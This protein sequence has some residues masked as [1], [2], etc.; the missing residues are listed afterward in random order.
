MARQG[1]PLWHTTALGMAMSAFIASICFLR[2]ERPGRYYL[3]WVVLRGVCGSTYWGLALFA[4]TLGASPGDVGSLMSVNVAMAALLG[5]C[6]LKEPLG[7]THLLSTLLT[8]TGAV[9]ISQ[10]SFIFQETGGAASSSWAGNL[11][12]ILAGVIQSFAF[13]CS[14]QVAEFSPL[15]AT[16]SCLIIASAICVLLP[17]VK[18]A[19][20]VPIGVM[21]SSPGVAVAWVAASTVIGLSGYGGAVFGSMLCPAAASTTAYTSGCMVFG[22]AAEFLFF[23]TSPELVRL[24][25]AALMVVAIGIMA[26]GNKR[27]RES[28]ETQLPTQLPDWQG[29]DSLGSDSL[30]LG[31]QMGSRRA[32]LTEFIFS[33]LSDF[34]PVSEGGRQRMSERRLSMRESARRDSARSYL[35]DLRFRRASSQSGGTSGGRASLSLDAIPGPDGTEDHKKASV[36]DI[37]EL[38]EDPVVASPEPL[39]SA[40]DGPKVHGARDREEPSAEAVPELPEKCTQEPVPAG[41]P[42]VSA[43]DGHHV[44][45]VSGMHPPEEDDDDLTFTI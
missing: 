19:D 44:C 9:L 45:G 33:E 37:P 17:A 2:P 6:F 21:W 18:L 4:V 31:S 5:R 22:Y 16:L 27:P 8:I 30:S 41:E 24:I 28:P 13:I 20:E 14:R 39:A 35:G 25:G 40:A 3:K 11:A 15:F 12:A 43:P 29:S 36:E 10:P 26:V 34:K 38:P 1:W 32:S 7:I 23:G 42:L